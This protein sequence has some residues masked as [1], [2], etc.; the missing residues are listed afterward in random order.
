[1]RRERAAVAARPGRAAEP[2]AGQPHGTAGEHDADV[3]DE[4]GPAER[5]AARSGR[6]GSLPREGPRGQDGADRG[7]DQQHQQGAPGEVAVQNACRRRLAEGTGGQQPGDV[8]EAAVRRR[9]EYDGPARQQQQVDEVR[10]RQR[11]LGAQHTGD[12][13]AQRREGSRPEHDRQ[14]RRE[15][16]RRAAASRAQRDRARSPRSAAPR[17]GAARRPCRAAARTAAA[18]RT[19]AA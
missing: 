1:M 6:R 7:P 5:G 14:Q 3:G 4:G 10:R 8:A 16:R 17:R 2:G 15:Q 12:E 9:G 13:Q 18:A 11:G 19:R